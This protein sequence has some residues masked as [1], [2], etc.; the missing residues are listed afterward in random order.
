MIF[1]DTFF[2][3]FHDLV[4]DYCSCNTTDSINEQ[5]SIAIV[6]YVA[7]SALGGALLMLIVVAILIA[8]I[9]YLQRKKMNSMS[10]LTCHNQLDIDNHEISGSSEL[11]QK[12]HT[13][14][15]PNLKLEASNPIYE[16]ALYETTPGESLKSFQSPPV[17]PSNDLTFRYTLDTTP[18]L[19]PP[20]KMSTT[21]LQTR[22]PGCEGDSDTTEYMVMSS[23]QSM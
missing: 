19:P 3:G 11:Q 14:R 1:T 13:L 4:G 16:G 6:K 17:T 9:K 20:R 5:K 21:Q 12:Q 10:R 18:K 8:L 7:S 15:P 22:R 2:Y 23:K